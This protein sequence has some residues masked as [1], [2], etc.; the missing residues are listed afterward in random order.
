M[1]DTN[2]RILE[3]IIRGYNVNLQSV[4]W[5]VEGHFSK[6]LCASGGRYLVDQVDAMLVGGN[7]A[8]SR[9]LDAFIYSICVQQLH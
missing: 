6:C 7:L 2:P 8:N 3:E 1:G 4:V 5:R 9:H